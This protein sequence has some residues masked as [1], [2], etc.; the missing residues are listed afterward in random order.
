MIFHLCRFLELMCLLAVRQRPINILCSTCVLQHRLELRWSLFLKT[1]HKDADEE[2][3]SFSA[4]Y[5][6][7]RHCLQCI[8]RWQC[9][10]F[11]P[12]P[13]LCIERELLPKKK[14]LFSAFRIWT[15]RLWCEFVWRKVDLTSSFYRW[16][17]N[18]TAQRPFITPALSFNLKEKWQPDATA[19]CYFR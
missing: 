2:C 17:Y 15:P 4:L 7:G 12:F 6:M 19:V 10:K 14:K 8:K 11:Q 18:I 5:K 1:W 16:C 3:G 9:L 13:L